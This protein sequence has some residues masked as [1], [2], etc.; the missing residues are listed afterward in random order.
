[1]CLLYKG[2]VHTI[3]GEP[4]GM[5]SWFCQ[6]IAAQ[7]VEES[8]TVL[9]VDLENS[10]KS[11]C[12]RFRYLGLSQEDLKSIDVINP[13]TVF[14]AAERQ[15]VEKYCSERAYELI[16]LDG[17]TDAMALFGLN[18][19]DSIDFARFDKGLLK[20]LAAT[21]AAVIYVDHVVKNK[22][23]RG[24]WGTGSQH[25]KAAID[26][27]AFGVDPV[28]SFGKGRTGK[29]RVILHKDK[30]GD[31]PQHALDGDH[32]T[33]AELDMHSNPDTHAIKATLANP[34]PDLNPD[35]RPTIIMAKI[36]AYVERNPGL[37]RDVIIKMSGVGDGKREWV[38]L[39]FQLLEAEG[40]IA[41]DLGDPKDRRYRHVKAYSEM[42][43]YLDHQREPSR[44]MTAQ[45]GGVHAEA[46]G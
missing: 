5:K 10:R 11:L 40:F 18:P 9:F 31:L 12:D 33:I 39:A 29:A 28:S 16:V 34:S 2:K 21:G 38:R 27:A 37:S 17:T 15:L 45:D 42:Q 30:N 23:E 22:D 46:Q 4:G 24:G 7:V 13:D 19:N 26:G 36:A 8:G 35:F 20:P 32:S 3:Y 14:S 25:K 6:V 1:M 41:Q 44:P 43:D